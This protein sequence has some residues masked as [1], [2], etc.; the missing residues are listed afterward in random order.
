MMTGKER[1]ERQLAHLPVDRMAVAEEFWG[2]T[3]QRWVAAG[4][5]QRGEDPV[6]HFELDLST[7][8][9]FNYT[10]HFDE[11][12]KRL[13]EDDETYLLLNRNH[14]RLRYH[15]TKT[16]PPENVAYEI[17]D[18]QSWEELA[19]PFIKPERG[20]INFAGYH[21]AKQDAAAHNRFFCWSGIP[22]FEN[23]H[24]VC[25]HE[26]ML[27]SMILD[28]DW[29]K[30]MCETYTELNIN[31]MEILFAEEGL[32][33]AIWFYE[34]MGFLQRPFM[35]PEMYKELIQPSHRRLCDYAHSLGLKVIMHSCGYVEPLLP[36]MIEAGI[37][38]LEAIEVKSGMDLLRID[39]N[40]GEQIALMGGLDIRPVGS[41]DQ[42]GIRRELESKL[43]LLKAH[44]GFIF[45]SD[46]S[47]PDSTDY[48]TY[49]YFLELGK[50]LGTY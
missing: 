31:L 48:D 2:Q 41:N 3:I 28:P 33:D 44:K 43:P 32:P 21:H 39:R 35:S 17:T 12:E 22:V 13:E 46:H 5:M 29:I 10:I 18:R 34:D 42:D 23:M 8:W 4:K 25:G 26:T 27:M 36:G 1:V 7:L 15:K 20:R 49:R 45:H 16:T 9:A 19:K 50:E 47:I 14:A 40:Y 37:N 11:Q 24:P 30:D 38:C 6:N